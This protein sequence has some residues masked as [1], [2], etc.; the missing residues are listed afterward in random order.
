MTR[1][2]LG[3]LVALLAACSA[4]ESHRG[5]GATSGGQLRAE[6]A[7]DTPPEFRPVFRTLDTLLTAGQRDTLRTALRDS[8]W[9]YHFSLGLFLRNEFGL[10]RGGPLQSYFLARGV[11]HPD[12]MSDVL[13]RAY[14]E[15]LRGEPVDV[16]ALIRTV[17][18]SP[19]LDSFR[20]APK[21]PS[22][23][24]RSTSRPSA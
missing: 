22:S 20:Q 10:W 5:A 15:H 23:R 19:P 13:L 2:V 7:S 17:T 14:G 11:H 16:P 6:A 24:R 21:A 18:A 4:P 9:R 3:L 8:A 1:R 12:D